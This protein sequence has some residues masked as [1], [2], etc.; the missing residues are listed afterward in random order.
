MYLESETEGYL[1]A[2]VLVAQKELRDLKDSSRILSTY[3]IELLLNY[4]EDTLLKGNINE[5]TRPGT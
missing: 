4:F 1:K 5:S 3:A 2:L